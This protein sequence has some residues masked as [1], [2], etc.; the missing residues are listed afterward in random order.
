[1]NKIYEINIIFLSTS[2]CATLK[3]S[4][5]TFLYFK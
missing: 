1:M 3:C 2:I 5:L 4:K